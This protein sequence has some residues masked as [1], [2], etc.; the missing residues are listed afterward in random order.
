MEKEE[1]ELEEL[2]ELSGEKS[3][4]SAPKY[5]LPQIR[6]NGQKGVFIK[7]YKDEQGVY[8]NEEIGKEISGVV[9]KIRRS[10]GAMTIDDSGEV[11]EIYFSN[12]HNDWRD[13]ALLFHKDLTKKKVKTMLLDTGTFK[14]LKSRYTN[15]KM[16]QIIYLLFGDDIV[17]LEVRGKGLSALFDYYSKFTGK[18]HIFQFTTKIGTIKKENKAV[19][20]YAMTFEKGENSNM[21]VVPLKIREVIDNIKKSEDYY[22]SQVPKDKF[23][24]KEIETIEEE[25]DKEIK[26][27]DI[28]V[29]EENNNPEEEEIPLP[30]EQ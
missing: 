11:E 12:E 16:R 20:Y 24:P 27:E 10:F 9:L 13:K 15:L 1:Q 7:T 4:R 25:S 19:E 28:P 23:V 17:K 8:L 2:A 6:L 18:E 3:V 30:E 22:A 21:D 26:Y 29:I 14:E 5:E